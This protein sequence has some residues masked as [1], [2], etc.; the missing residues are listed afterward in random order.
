SPRFRELLAKLEAQYDLLI[1][2]A[3]PAF[4]TSDAQLLSRHI[5][6]MVLVSRAQVD[7]R[8][9]LQRLYRELDGQRADILGVLLNGVEASVGGYM[10][11]NFREFHE[12]SGPERRKARRSDL[13]RSNGNGSSNGTQKNHPPA[14]IQLQEDIAQDVF[15]GMEDEPKDDDR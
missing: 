3:P 8:G 13:S 2:D 12:Y 1:I 11:R 10:K 14:A 7:T 15:G 4:L 6:A 9:M 5:D